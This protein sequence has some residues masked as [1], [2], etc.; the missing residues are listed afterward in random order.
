MPTMCIINFAQ[1]LATFYEH[2]TLPRT[3]EEATAFVQSVAGVDLEG[4]ALMRA[5]Y[6]RLTGYV[7]GCL[8]KMVFGSVP[9][10]DRVPFRQSA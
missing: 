2:A 10:G 8:H 9:S 3:T 7:R 4:E 6:R 1:A 5:T